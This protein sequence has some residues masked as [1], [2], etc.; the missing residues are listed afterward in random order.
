MRHAPVRDA[1]HTTPRTR[2]TPHAIRPRTWG[3]VIVE[4]NPPPR[5]PASR[6]TSGRTLS[7]ILGY[8]PVTLREKVDIA[9]ANERLAEIAELRSLSALAERTVLLRLL[10]RLDEA[11]D[12]ANAALRLTRFTG[13]RKDLAAARLRRAQVLQFQGRL[14]EAES[15]MTAVA[16]DA[17]T[18]EWTRIEAFARQHR[19]KVHFDAGDLPAALADFTAAVFLREKYGAPAEQM[20]ASLTAVLVVES[21]ISDSQAE[22]RPVLR[23]APRTA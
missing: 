10:G 19:G 17:A 4:G 23:L 11:F 14:A 7:I 3:R 20:E 2:G 12:V 9:A 18:H 8:D 21:L 22:T 16:E 15:E 1:P 5:E 13:E 6:R